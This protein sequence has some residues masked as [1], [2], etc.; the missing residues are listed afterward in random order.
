MWAGIIFKAFFFPLSSWAISGRAF[1]WGNIIL[2]VPGTWLGIT[3]IDLGTFETTQ[4]T[5][6]GTWPGVK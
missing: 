3:S 1:F 4:K 6:P 2:G 5:V